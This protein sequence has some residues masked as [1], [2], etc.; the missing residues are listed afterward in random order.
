MKS[1]QTVNSAK[2]HTTRSKQLKL[3]YDENKCDDF[4]SSND[5]TSMFYTLF[6][7]LLFL[8]PREITVTMNELLCICPNAKES[9]VR[10]INFC[11]TFYCC[12]SLH[13]SLL[14]SLFSTHFSYSLTLFVNNKYVA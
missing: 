2:C 9:R 3:I 5:L 1:L 12:F 11:P 7:L 8:V 4:I 14:F 13:F 6:L 10:L